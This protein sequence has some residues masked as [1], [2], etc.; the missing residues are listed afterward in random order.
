[1]IEHSLF[2]TLVCE[3]EYPESK[4]FK[5]IFYENIH[6]YMTPDGYSSEFTGH[7][8]IHHEPTFEPFFKYAMY[9]VKQYTKRLHI[10]NSKFNF[11]LVK[12]WLNTKKDNSTPKHAHGDAHISFT[13]YVNVPNTFSRPIR[14]YNHDKMHEPYP[15]SLRWNNTENI[16]DQ[17]NALTWS[18]EPKEGHM[19]VFPST[20]VHDT[21]GKSDNERDEGAPTKEKLNEN[22][23]CLAAD[24]IITYN[25]QT[26]SPLGLQ[27]ISNWRTF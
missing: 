1:M 9:C 20:L 25:E 5:S 24:I 21:L 14:F 18:L 10:D 4:K 26:A 23:I 15:G 27:P 17:F 13:Y 22:R 3:F 12:T 8:N 6:N 19:F 11:N 16:W 7:V 2:P